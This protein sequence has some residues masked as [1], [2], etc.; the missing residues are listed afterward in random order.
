MSY[1]QGDEFS[2]V[3]ENK[4]LGMEQILFVVRTHFIPC[5]LLRRLR[6]QARIYKTF[7]KIKKSIALNELLYFFVLLCTKAMNVLA[8][9][10]EESSVLL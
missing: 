7:W 6:G 1:F 5:G 2:Y 3:C 8:F 9:K 4:G 10:L